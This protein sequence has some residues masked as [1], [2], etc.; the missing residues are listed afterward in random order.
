MKHDKSTADRPREAGLGPYTCS[1][2]LALALTS[3]LSGLLVILKELNKET[4]F[5]AMAALTG[6]HWVTHGVIDLLLFGGLGW[7]LVRY[8]AWWQARPAQLLWVL[9]GGV[10]LG[11]ALVAGF[12]I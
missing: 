6:H 3:V 11:C 7:W 2:A 9:L 1:F 12:F 5:A 10:L 8:S 4:V